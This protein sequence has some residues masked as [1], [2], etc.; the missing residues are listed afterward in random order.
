MLTSTSGRP[1]SASA[2]SKAAAIWSGSRMSQRDGRATGAAQLARSRRGRLEVLGLAAG[3]DDVGAEAGELGGDGLAQPGAAAGDEHDRA[4]EGAG[5]QGAARAAAVRAG[6]VA[7]SVGRRR[8]VGH[9][10]ARDRRDPCSGVRGSSA[11][12]AGTRRS[13]RERLMNGLADQ[14]LGH[15]RPHLGLGQVAITRRAIFTVTAATA[16]IFSAISRTVASSSS[17]GTT[18]RRRRGRAPPRRSSARPVSTMSLATPV[19]RHLEQPGDATGVGDHAV[20][21]LGQ[22][23][24]GALGRDAD[25]AQQ[26]PLERAADRPALA[27]HDDRR[28]EVE[29]LQ[30]A[31]VAPLH[32]LVVGQLGLVGADR[33]D[34]AARREALALAPP[35]DR[36]DLGL[37]GDA[38]R[39]PRTAATSMS[40][41]KALCLS[42]L[43]L[44]RTAMWS[45]M[46]TWTV[47]ATAGSLLALVDTRRSVEV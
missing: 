25:V 1:S 12:A 33:A 30:D 15:R 6:R 28:V 7:S 39:A 31:A 4:V 26:R 11:R 8:W 38:R 37:G 2:A 10:S 17:A 9:R 47:P 21:R 42:G 19:A 16:A 20:A 23:E 44:V 29:D 32:Q 46:V 5:G 24:P 45:S 22:H 34:V 40:S 36:P 43:S 13:R 41:S 27:G 18:R 35:D 14:L 3:D